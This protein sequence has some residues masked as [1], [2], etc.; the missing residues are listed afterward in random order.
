MTSLLLLLALIACED[1]DPAQ[2]PPRGPP[3]AL[4]P[5]EQGHEGHEHPEDHGHGARHGGQQR[6]L[7]GMHVEALF[8]KDG[9]HF[10]LA[11][12][13]NQPLA[14]TF[15]TGHALVTGPAGTEDV[16]L[17]VHDD[18]LLAAK[19]LSE[20]QPASALLSLSRDGKLQSVNFETRGVGLAFHDHTPLH[21]GAVGMSGHYH[22]EL[23][24]TPGRFQVWLTDAGRGA[25]T[26]DLAGVIV[27]GDQRVPLQ[28]DTSTG[29]LVAESAEAGSAA[30][31]VELQHDGRTI[32]L[33][34]TAP[35]A[36]DE[37][38]PASP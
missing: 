6:E 16:A 21:G 38:G 36:A 18:H 25:I 9:V 35:A 10:Y 22:I 34:F 33:P 28:L 3:V 24:T 2:V 30:V 12:A 1:R 37:K 14:P 11:D 29:A 15:A 5:E 8:Q 7:E 27:L 20:G 32:A 17:V 31:V 19:G 26:D 13:D 4:A 23:L